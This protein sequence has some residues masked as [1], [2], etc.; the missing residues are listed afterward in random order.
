MGGLKSLL[1]VFLVLVGCTPNSGSEVIR[2]AEHTLEYVSIGSNT[3]IHQSRD[4]AVEILSHDNEGNPIKG[5]GA[6]VKYKKH[7]FI[8]TAAHVVS[9]TNIAMISHENEKIIAEVVYL[10]N[11]SDIAVLKIEGMF[12]R[13]PLAWRPAKPVVGDEVLYTGFP[14]G[15]KNLTIEGKVSGYT[16]SDLI[17]H[18]YAW[19]G[20]SGS[21]VLDKR[22][23]IV[24]ILS[25]VDIGRAFGMFPQI[26]ED[27]VIVIPI[28]KLKIEDLV[29]SMSI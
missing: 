7:H 14:N 23:R 2:G 16:G 15:Y 20:S 26:V 6:Y 25:A 12:T 27:I 29:S 17:V 4:A 22:G 3:G 21:I 11:L 8:L 13:K 18:S 1:V 19:S 5:T 9:A 10:D 28:H 24:G